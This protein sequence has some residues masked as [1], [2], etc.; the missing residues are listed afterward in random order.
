MVR[1]AAGILAL[2]GVG[3]AYMQL[4]K[5][6]FLRYNK[7]DH[8]DRGRLRAGDPAPDLTLSLYEG[9]SVAL[10]SLWHDRPVFL[11]FGSCT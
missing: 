11:V 6:A 10:S 7:W 1:S 5:A 9:G 2:A 4:V 3:V 8:R